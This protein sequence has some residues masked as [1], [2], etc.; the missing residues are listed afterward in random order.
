MGMNDITT[1]ILGQ[2]KAEVPRHHM[3]NSSLR[4]EPT[5]EIEWRIVFQEIPNEELTVSL[6]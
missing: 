2:P 6:L 4:F 3:A 1:V 5:K